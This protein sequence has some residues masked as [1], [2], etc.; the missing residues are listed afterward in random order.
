[1][2]IVG[3]MLKGLAESTRWSAW[4]TRAALL[5]FHANR[6]LNRTY[7]RKAQPVSRRRHKLVAIGDDAIEG[8]GDYCT[9]GGVTTGPVPR[10]QRMIQ[11]DRA[12]VCSW[13]LYNCGRAGRLAARRAQ[14]RRRH[15]R[16][17]E[18]EDG[19]E[20]TTKQQGSG[21]C[22]AK[23]TQRVSWHAVFDSDVYRDAE[24]VVVSL[25]ANDY[26]R[27]PKTAQ[28]T[29]TARNFVRI[30]TELCRRGKTVFL[31]TTPQKLLLGEHELPD[32]EWHF[33][34]V[35]NTILSD[36]LFDVTT[37]RKRLHELANSN[38]NSTS[39]TTKKTK[40]V[41]ISSTSESKGV[42]VDDDKS[43]DSDG[44]AKHEEKKM[45]KK[46]KKKKKKKKTLD[47]VLVQHLFAGAD[48]GS[49]DYGSASYYGRTARHFN[50]TGYAVCQGPLRARATRAR[51]CA[52]QRHQ[53]TVLELLQTS[54]LL[55]STSGK[56]KIRYDILRY[57]SIILTTATFTVHGL[58]L[59][60]QRATL[61]AAR[62]AHRAPR[63]ETPRG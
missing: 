52:I 10:M 61:G 3:R 59:L 6:C 21:G 47:P 12:I 27:S 62:G 40:S 41:A 44:D 19:K 50:S 28:A 17:Q 42:V 11:K 63:D 33:V 29:V 51:A 37:E 22:C 54:Y 30:C 32:A 56:Y 49:W 48:L 23:L 57:V 26:R 35:L 7:P 43:H 34:N 5:W 20:K 60:E 1:M 13:L 16:R 39:G 9:C 55:N 36:W 2:G 4:R 18:E 38:S 58:V 14:R 15:R 24:V 25:G 31:C 46:K 45:T 8:L 53:A